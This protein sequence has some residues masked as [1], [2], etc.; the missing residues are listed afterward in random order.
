MVWDKIDNLPHPVGTEFRDPGVIIFARPD[1][2]VELVVIGDV[3]SVQALGAGL[4]IGRC[5]G[6]TDPKLIKIRHNFARLPE[7]EVLVEL[8]AVGRGWDAWITCLH[9]VYLTNP[10][11]V[12]FSLNSPATCWEFGAVFYRVINNI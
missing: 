6:M 12:N 7:G 9:H 11:Y 2:G 4:E 3:V 10:C 1:C 8:Q 5:V